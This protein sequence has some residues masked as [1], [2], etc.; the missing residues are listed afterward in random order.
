MYLRDGVGGT[1]REAEVHDQRIGAG[2]KASEPFV[3][4]VLIA[5][6][7]HAAITNSDPVG[8]RRHAAVGHSD[9]AHFEVVVG[10]DRR[11]SAHHGVDRDDVEP[12]AL[13]RLSQR[14]TQYGESPATAIEEPPDERVDGGKRSGP[15]GSGD[16]QRLLTSQLAQPQQR[17]KVGDVIGV[18]V[19]DGQQG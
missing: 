8:N 6:E 3:A 9:G 1:C 15:R 16:L 10:P 11:W 12:H 19:A 13:P 18:E 5:A 7:H 17:R 4:A 2:G 14:P